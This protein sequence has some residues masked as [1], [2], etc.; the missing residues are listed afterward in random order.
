VWFVSPDTT[1]LEA[2]TLMSVKQVGALLVMKDDQIAGMISERDFV[3]KIAHLHQ[4]GVDIPVKEYMTT[5]VF[6]VATENSIEECMALMTDKHIRHLPVLEG[7]KL[8][9]MI[10]IGDLVK[11]VIEDKEGTI[12]HLENYIAGTYT[13]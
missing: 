6:T 12:K 10:S 11:E 9:G 3:R 13:Q 7:E 8:V 4:C 1:V 2:L 5:K